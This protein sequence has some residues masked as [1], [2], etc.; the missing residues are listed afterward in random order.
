MHEPTHDGPRIGEQFEVELPEIPDEVI[1]ATVAQQ[2]A[3]QGR[4]GVLLDLGRYGQ[5]WVS[6]N[7]LKAVRV[8]ASC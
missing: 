4:P 5:R 7:L 3:R 1:V 8:D 6:F 2:L